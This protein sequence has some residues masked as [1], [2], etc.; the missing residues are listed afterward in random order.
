MSKKLRFEAPRAKKK[1]LLWHGKFT[2][3]GYQE[4]KTLFVTIWCSNG[5]ICNYWMIPKVLGSAVRYR[6]D[7]S[8]M[9]CFP[10]IFD[11]EMVQSAP[12]TRNPQNLNQ[13]IWTR[14]CWPLQEE[15]IPISVDKKT[16]S[17]QFWLFYRWETLCWPLA[18]SFGKHFSRF[19]TQ[20]MIY[21]KGTGRSKPEHTHTN[22][23]L[24]LLI[25]H[26]NSRAS[27]IYRLHYV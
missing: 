24:N 16:A 8:S 2:F 26:P 10:Q 9:K 27:C 7:R 22:N 25:T 21:G 6:V 15:L 19:W 5:S 13:T 17:F 4:P 20:G 18:Y 14:K 12:V 1:V 23:I 3:W 11:L